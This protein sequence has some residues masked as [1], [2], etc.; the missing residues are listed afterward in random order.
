M[1]KP[2]TRQSI[3]AKELPVFLTVKEL[4]EMLRVKVRTVYSWVEND[5]IPY[6]KPGRITIFRL[7]EIIG[8]LEK[9]RAEERE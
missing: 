4:A 1:D 7:D 5:L 2:S 3:T 8:W 9:K 6:H